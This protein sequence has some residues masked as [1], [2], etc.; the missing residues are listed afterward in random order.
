MGSSSTVTASR[1]R[2]YAGVATF[3]DAST[4]GRYLSHRLTQYAAR[5]LAR[6]VADAETSRNGGRFGPGLTY[7][8]ILFSVNDYPL[9]KSLGMYREELG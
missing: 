9:L 8:A 3:R 1:A 7:P 2:A 6:S 4:S 5:A